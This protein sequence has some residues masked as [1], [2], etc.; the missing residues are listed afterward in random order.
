MLTTQKIATVRHEIFS[1]SAFPAGND[2]EVRTNGPATD[3]SGFLP[4]LDREGVAFQDQLF[5][6]EQSGSVVGH[7]N[8][9][10]RGDAFTDN[11]L[12]PIVDRAV[13]LTGSTNERP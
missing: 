11:K 7:V 4:N 13:P 5:C 10:R 9:F 8:V 6:V 2:L 12:A 3:K 1:K